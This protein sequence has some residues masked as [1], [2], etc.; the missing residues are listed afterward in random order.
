MDYEPRAVHPVECH[1]DS[2]LRTTPGGECMCQDVAVLLPWWLFVA[3][4]SYNS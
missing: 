1:E 3:K 4:P 2:S